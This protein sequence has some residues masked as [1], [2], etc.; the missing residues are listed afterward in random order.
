MRLH[1]RWARLALILAVLSLMAAACSSSD[2]AAGGGATDEP[3]STPAADEPTD[4]AMASDEPTDDSAAP[5]GDIAF[6]VGVTEEACPEGVNPDNGCIYLGT[7]S[8]LTQGPFAA[9]AVPITDAQTRFW[10]QVNAGGGIGG[11]DIN[12]AEY[13]R[14]NQYNPE[15]HSQQYEE[16]KGNILAIAQSLGSPTTFAIIDDLRTNNVV[17]APASWTSAWL[18]EDVIIESGNTYCI[19]AQNGLDYLAENGDPIE[20]VMAVHFPGDYGDDG[21]AGARNWAE[22]N[23]AEF[24][25]VPTTPGADNQGEAVGQIVGGG[26]DVVVITT[27]PTDA[28]TLV[29]QAAA[30]GYTGRFL[31]NSPS[32]NPGLMASPAAPA[33]IGQVTVAGP[34]EPFQTDTPGHQA[35]RDALGDIEG[36]DGYT[37]GWVWS[38]PML[39]VITQA[40]ENGDLTRQGMI[41]AVG[42]ITEVDYQ[43]M[44]PEG[45]GNLSGDANG[46][47]VRATS[48]AI[49][50]DEFPSGLDGQGFY[51]GDTAA[52]FEFG[53]EAC[54]VG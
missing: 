34:W 7:I 31:F 9:L 2:D 14:D 53:E 26:A 40:V 32:F 51:E 50:T 18:F 36:N 47:A 41:D 13:T 19:E 15:V 27:G 54:Y 10:E 46:S 17:T 49:P 52:A 6:D 4:D 39:A 22:V 24:I 29:G 35:M 20:T 16:I 30:A 21:A 12:T 3:A 5:A 25:D 43:G 37:S 28:G 45:S 1:S 33:V 42:Q 38:Y 23:G 8:D 44:L 11:F 48:I